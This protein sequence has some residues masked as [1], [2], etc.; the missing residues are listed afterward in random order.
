MV[1]RL[2]RRGVFV[3]FLGFGS[4]RSVRYGDTGSH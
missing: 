2:L 1:D 3:G 4:G